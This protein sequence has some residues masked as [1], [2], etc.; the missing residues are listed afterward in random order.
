[1]NDK[2]ILQIRNLFNYKGSN[3]SETIKNLNSYTFIGPNYCDLVWVEISPSGS[4]FDIKWLFRGQEKPF[5]KKGLKF[6]DVKK[7]VKG[8]Q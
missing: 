7:I 3:H 2:Q 4:N 8:Y 1:M 5:K 6:S